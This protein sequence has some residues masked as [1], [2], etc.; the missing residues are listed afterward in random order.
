MENR[1][2]LDE[3][4]QQIIGCVYLVSN[5]LGSGFLEKVYENA[6]CIEH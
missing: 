2:I 1:L 5:A 4:T 6:L 3:I